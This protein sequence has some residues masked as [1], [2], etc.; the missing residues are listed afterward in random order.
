MLDALVS[1]DA[2]GFKGS[3]LVISRRGLSVAPSHPVT[4]C[5][6]VVDPER[7]PLTARTVLRT[8]Q[9]A[10]KKIAGSGGAWQSLVSAMREATPL[11]R[12]SEPLSREANLSAPF[13]RLLGGRTPSFGAADRAPRRGMARRGQACQWAARI[14]QL[15]ATEDGSLQVGLRFR[16]ASVVS[17]F[18]ARRG[19]QLHRGRI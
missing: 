14:H 4:E 19:D 1:L 15:V 9:H 11:I 13:A 3:V 12:N 7:L 6:E 16:G 2:H 5:P 18:A 17:V 10:R 8:L